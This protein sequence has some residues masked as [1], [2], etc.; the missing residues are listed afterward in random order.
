[1]YILHLT[2]GFS[3]V[4][5]KCWLQEIGFPGS[6]QDR[7]NRCPNRR[8]EVMLVKEKCQGDKVQCWGL[9][10]TKFTGT[11]DLGRSVLLWFYLFPFFLHQLEFVIGWGWGRVCPC[12]FRLV[13][14]AILLKVLL[15]YW[16][17]ISL[18]N[19]FGFLKINL[20]FES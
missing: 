1:M 19:F 7:W 6:R 17:F 13:L 8:T 11:W 14:K 5:I 3:P 18:A 9:C 20:C 4:F 16:A 10:P 15:F 12:C 2:P